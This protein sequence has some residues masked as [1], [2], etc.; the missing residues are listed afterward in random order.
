MNLTSATLTIDPGG[1]VTFASMP[2][3]AW[4]AAP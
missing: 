1:S 4:D 2:W 3:D